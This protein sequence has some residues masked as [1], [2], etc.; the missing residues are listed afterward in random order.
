MSSGKPRRGTYPLDG[1]A[2][3]RLLGPSRDSSGGSGGGQDESSVLSDLIHGFFLEDDDDGSSTTETKRSESDFDRDDSDRMNAIEKLLRRCSVTSS[4]EVDSYKELLASHVERAMEVFS[5][6]ETSKY[7]CRRRKVVVLLQDIGH[8]ASLCKT[9]WNFGRG[10]TAGS[11]EFIDVVSP[12]DHR[13]IIELDL[14]GEFDIAR[15]TRQYSRLM[16]SL[17][18]VFVGKIEEL[19]M[20]VKAMTEAA[21][22]SLKSTGLT[23]P[24][25]RKNCFMNNKWFGPY[26]RNMNPD[27]AVCSVNATVKCRSFGFEDSNGGTAVVR[28]R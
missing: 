26:R 5:R 17:P 13:Y 19:K 12:C 11:H 3:S 10:V 25:W 18:G 22:I 4:G 2:I 1:H 6:T 20:I 16:Q 14:A 23:V 7:A 24:P 15:P 28:T 9:K 27:V 21:K 8:N